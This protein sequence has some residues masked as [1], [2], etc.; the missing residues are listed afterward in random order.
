MAAQSVRPSQFITTFGPGSILEGPDGPRVVYNLARSD[1]FHSRPI[2]EFAIDDAGLSR[3]IS[4]QTGTSAQI[5]RLPTNADFNTPDGESIYATDMFPKWSLCI[6]HS[7][8]YRRRP[9]TDG[10]RTGCPRCVDHRSSYHAHLRSRRE[11]IRFIQACK[12]G[13]MD[14]VAWGRLIK[15]TSNCRPQYLNWKGGGASLRDVQLECPN[16]LA[17]V[18]LGEAYS[19]DLPCSACYPERGDLSPG[20]TSANTC[21]RVARMM[22]R[23]ATF[24]YSPE[25][26]SAITIPNLDTPLHQFMASSQRLLALKTMNRFTKGR[27]DANDVKDTLNPPDAPDARAANVLLPFG[28]AF[29]LKTAQE[30]LAHQFPETSAELLVH[31]FT[32]L[33]RAATHG[34]PS[35]PSS[36]KGNPPLFE[37]IPND[38]RTDL[39]WPGTTSGTRFR[40]SPVS[41]LRV[42]MA[43]LGYR[44]LDDT[45]APNRSDLV[46]VHHT[47]GADT[48]Y[49]GVELFGEGVF[50]DLTP[51][52]DQTS[53]AFHPPMNSDDA[54]AWQAVFD[55]DTAQVKKHPVFVWWHTLA[56]RLIVA[57]SVDS[58]YSS[59][60]IRERVYVRVNADGTATGGILLYTVQPG[61]DG[62]LGGLIALIPRFERVLQSALERVDSCSNDPLCGEEIFNPNRPN[63]AICY[64]CG[65]VSETSCEHRNMQLDRNLLWRHPLK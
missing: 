20:A 38:V 17:T 61:G 22:Q 54:R 36:T 33:Q 59:A 21:N 1:V 32:Q 4:S 30:V 57:L 51:S 60:S 58:G 12:A 5:V 65:L 13:H 53:I 8:L 62:T 6:E 44:R 10:N 47:E 39:H 31:E 18:N 42:V 11:A 46:P 19:R 49:P 43:L 15:H 63:G 9:A 26:I 50:I 40:V 34:H 48:W 52:A 3:I 27:F 7:I 25:H 14:D 41:R 35:M 64:A 55:E 2:S 28:D 45:P 29:I 56:H 24:L 23:G 37:V 16:C